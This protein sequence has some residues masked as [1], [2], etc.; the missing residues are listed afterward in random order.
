MSN[1][2]TPTAARIGADLP[3]FRHWP[4]PEKKKEGCHDPSDTDQD[5]GDMDAD[6]QVRQV[7]AV[8]PISRCRREG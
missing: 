1:E 4:T 8:S 6:F 5:I 7:V 3:I 2:R